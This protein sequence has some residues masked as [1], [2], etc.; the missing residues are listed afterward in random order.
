MEQ[1]C[2][3]QHSLKVGQRVH[4]VMFTGVGGMGK[5][6]LTLQKQ[7]LMHARTIRLAGIF[8][9]EKPGSVMVEHKTCTASV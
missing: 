4:T 5:I 2:P 3:L 9:S 8:I 7:T 6:N 1:S